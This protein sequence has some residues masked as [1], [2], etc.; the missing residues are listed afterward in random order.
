MTHLKFGGK[1]RYDKV[2]YLFTAESNSEQI[3]KLVKIFQYYELI[4]SGMFFDSRCI[5]CVQ[6]FWCKVYTFCPSS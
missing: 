5:C 2:Y 6:Y 1:Y 4:P 3:S